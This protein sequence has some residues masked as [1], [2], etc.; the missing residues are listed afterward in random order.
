MK[1]LAV[2][3]AGV[4]V[5][6][7]AACSHA[8]APAAASANKA[9]VTPPVSCSQQYR[10]WAHGQGKGLMA[11]LDAISSAEEA[12]HAHV[13]TV[14]LSKAKSTVTRAAHYPIPACADPR[15]YWTVLVMHVNAAAS[16]KS[17]SSVR[18]AMKDVPKI[19]HRLRVEL[20]S[21]AQ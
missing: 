20:R 3:A 8:A 6:G 7:L 18:A 11:A 10:T 2:A 1:C 5:V 9:T 14:A 19:A 13:L 17:A 21:F 12:G 4:A 15:G 16:T